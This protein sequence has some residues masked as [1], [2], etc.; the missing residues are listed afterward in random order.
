MILNSDEFDKV[1]GEI[2]KITNTVTQKS[3]IGQT[4]SHRLNH[5]KYRPFGYLG[6]FKDHVSEANSQ[7]KNQSWYLN[8]SILKY[9]AEKFVCEKILECKL[10]ELDEYESH[11]ISEYNTKYPNGYNLTDGG[12]RGANLRCEKIILNESE[13]VKPE[14][15]E[16]MGVRRSDETKKLMSERLKEAKKSDDHRK[17]MSLLTQTQHSKQKF[18]RFKDVTI[19]ESKIDQ[20]LHVRKCHRTDTEYVVVIIKKAKTSFVGKTEKIE[21]IKVR[22][23]T[24]IRELIKWQHDQIAGTSLETS[25]TTSLLETTDEGTRVMTDPNGK[26]GEVLDNPQPSF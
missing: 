12:Q 20:Y 3:Y 25:Q 4:R 16:R 17:K 2:Y 14:P 5:S 10:D 6:R 13:L 11:Y 1:I 8:S 7:K 15:K 23:R 26:T 9:G 21:D 22:A 19:E 24:F 18:D